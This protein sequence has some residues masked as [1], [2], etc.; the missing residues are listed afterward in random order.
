MKLNKKV[1]N[2]YK[3]TDPL[4]RGRNR[5]IKTDLKMRPQD[6]E[7]DVK[8]EKSLEG[9]KPWVKVQ[10]IPDPENPYESFEN[11]I[12][13]FQTS[14]K[15]THITNPN[16]QNTEIEEMSCMSEN[17]NW[18][19]VQGVS[20][21]KITPATYSLSKKYFA[22]MKKIRTWKNG[23]ARKSK[24]KSQVKKQSDYRKRAMQIA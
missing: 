15:A 9:G 14:K 16:T 18:E 5:A 17:L 21:R 1:K 3:M 23:Q 24:P 12:I 2:M 19:G 20:T 13:S 7:D 4:E 11:E 8:F 6:L 10:D 22:Y